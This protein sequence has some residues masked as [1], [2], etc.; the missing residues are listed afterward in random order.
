MNIPAEQIASKKV[1]GKVGVSKV[2]QIKLIGGLCLM[3]L[4]KANPEVIGVGSH[5]AIC[6]HLAQQKHP[7]IEFTV[8]EKGD[9]VP[10]EHFK[11]LLPQYEELTNRFRKMQGLE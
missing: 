11:D 3:V 5:Q 7:D 8:L 6:R 4:A 9:F 2:Y 10:Y 1:V